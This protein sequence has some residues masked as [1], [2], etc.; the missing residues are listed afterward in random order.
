[1]AILVAKGVTPRE[2]LEMETD[3]DSIPAVYINETV[4]NTVLRGTVKKTLLID[5]IKDM[6]GSGRQPAIG[7]ISKAGE[8]EVR[9]EGTAVLKKE[10][11]RAGW[12]HL[13]HGDTCLQQIK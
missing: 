4:E 9:T 2:I 1:M 8:K 7:Q 10:S 3:M 13:K 6:G 12:T 5:L 11:W